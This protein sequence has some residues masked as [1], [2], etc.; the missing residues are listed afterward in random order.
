MPQIWLNQKVFD[1]LMGLPLGN[2]DVNQRILL[3]IG[4]SNL[5]IIYKKP[6]TDN[7]SELRKKRLEKQV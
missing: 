5:R 1:L 4:K 7:V 6:E 2:S 3:L